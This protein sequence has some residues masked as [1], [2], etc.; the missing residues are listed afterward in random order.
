MYV[1]SG[2]KLVIVG[3]KQVIVFTVTC[4]T[5]AAWSVTRNRVKYYHSGHAPA[6]YC[7]SSENVNSVGVDNKLFKAPLSC[8]LLTCCL[9]FLMT[10]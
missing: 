8:F 3:E 1:H 5:I 10:A 4:K 7:V 2:M 9:N 6:R